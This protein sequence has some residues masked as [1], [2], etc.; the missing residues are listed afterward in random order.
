MQCQFCG[1]TFENPKAFEKHKCKAMKRVEYFDEECFE[2]FKLYQ[3]KMCHKKN[4]DRVEYLKSSLFDCFINMK[5][6][7]NGNMLYAPDYFSKMMIFKVKLKEWTT[8]DSLHRYLVYRSN[9]ETPTQGI[10]RSEAY[11]KK[12]GLDIYNLDLLQLVGYIKDGWL[13]KHYF[14]NLGIDLRKILPSEYLK[15]IKDFV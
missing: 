12:K 2:L 4:I 11:L 8:P 6:F 5:E 14:I 13:S 1:K 7:I 10:E 9:M 3:Q 15:E